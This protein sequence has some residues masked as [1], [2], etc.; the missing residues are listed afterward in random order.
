MI[1]ITLT[2]CGTELVEIERTDLFV[3]FW[4]YL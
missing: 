1:R 4:C 3:F 2:L